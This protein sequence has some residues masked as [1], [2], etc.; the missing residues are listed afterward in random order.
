ME[1][2]TG[3]RDRLVRRCS[4][5]GVVIQGFS[6]KASDLDKEPRLQECRPLRNGCAFVGAAVALVAICALWT[7]WTDG[8]S[9]LHEHEAGQRERSLSLGTSVRSNLRP[10]GGIHGEVGI[11]Q[12]FDG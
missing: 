10:N 2:S 12:S 4:S 7:I 5:H 3:Q 8:T 11:G 6:M 1:V 9:T